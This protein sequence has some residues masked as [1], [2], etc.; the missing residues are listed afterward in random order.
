MASL[1]QAKV[2]G[3]EEWWH[4][5]CFFL[6]AKVFGLPIF[7]ECYTLSDIQR[8]GD[9]MRLKSVF[10]CLIVVIT[11]LFTKNSEAVTP[12]TLK[13]W[14]HATPAA[15]LMKQVEKDWNKAHPDRP[16]F[17]DTMVAEFSQYHS[18]LMI[19]LKTGKGGPDLCDI[20][21]TKVPSFLGV[22][23]IH[24]LPIDDLVNPVK[25]F[26]DSSRL[27]LYM[28]NNTHY[29][30]DYHIGITVMYYNK[31]IL[32]KAKVNA[33][34]IDTWDDF[35]RAGKQVVSKT[36]KPM[37]TIEAGDINGHLAITTQRGSNF[38]DKNGN[39]IVNKEINVSTMQ[40][41]SDLI[42]KD[43]IAIVSPGGIHYSEYYYEFMNKGGAA[44]V[45]MPLWYMTTFVNFMPDLKGKMIVRPLP[46]WKKGGIR[47]A[48]LGGT[49]TFI[50][51]QC[52]KVALAKEFLKEAKLT[53]DANIRI[54]NIMGIDPSRVD[55]Y[56]ELKK[57]PLNKF[58]GYFANGNEIVSLMIQLKNEINPVNYG[59]LFP[60]L[61]DIYRSETAYNVFAAKKQTPKEAMDQLQQELLNA[62]KSGK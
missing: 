17:I 34:S 25:K 1:R 48:A 31:E 33:D 37:L 26:F 52:K 27:A 22:D 15:S 16:L 46:R 53:R 10:V 7:S 11:I 58:T 35:I 40:F 55:I 50:T 56:D 47:S 57:L 13:F 9:M 30:T 29:A 18:R 51:D 36:K 24:L 62:Q 38:L 60:L 49:G 61:K 8:K 45:L 14:T 42:N 6:N 12:D 41:L 59:K 19:A 32:D 21:V 4:E 44:A 28:K 39:P 2:N 3:I 43:S 54:W 23:T 20:E 5:I